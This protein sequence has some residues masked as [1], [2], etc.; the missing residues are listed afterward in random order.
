MNIL[1]HIVEYGSLFQI[2]KLNNLS[3]VDFNN[4]VND[5]EKNISDIF[6]K[7]L[8]NYWI[9]PNPYKSNKE[10]LCDIMIVFKEYIIII[11]DKSCGYSKQ[12][13]KSSHK[14][15]A[16]FCDGLS[17]SKKQLESAMEYIKNNPKEIYIDNDSK[18]KIHRNIKINKDTKFLL[19]T[20]V[21]KW[22]NIVRENLK[23]DGSLIFNNSE[24]FIN[25]GLSR[26]QPRNIFN[27]QNFKK[28]GFFYHMIDDLNLSRILKNINTI[29]DLIEYLLYRENMF[30][31]IDVS[32]KT[33]KDILLPFL[34]KKAK[35]IYNL[36][37]GGNGSF[38]IKIEELDSNIDFFNDYKEYKQYI[39]KEKII[40][41]EQQYKLINSGSFFYDFL[42]SYMSSIANENYQIDKGFS[43]PMNED[44]SE[45][46]DIIAG[47]S[48]LERICITN[49]IH[50]KYEDM[51]LDLK[52]EKSVKP[53]QLPNG[54]YVYIFFYDINLEDLS[55][56]DEEL[57]NIS[58]LLIDAHN[59]DIA[60]ATKNFVAFLFPSP[61]CNFKKVTF[62]CN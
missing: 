1:E 24:D 60:K 25:N 43:T 40:N 31:K 6:R 53:I 29:P 36:L 19:I 4:Y 12:E 48:R 23:N 35:Y 51:F 57:N 5:A 52:K 58:N 54:N 37:L 18:C 26:K 46:F 30:Q 61:N 39:K 20:S 16:N 11:S 15:W 2:T 28:D 49:S 10:E 41:V 13:S 50:R 22:S 27:L 21:S 62:I 47:F 3:N 33:E 14:K 44:P 56:L 42:L 32:G 59:R 17:K 38:K 7:S 9:I 34:E 8:L 45:A 55:L